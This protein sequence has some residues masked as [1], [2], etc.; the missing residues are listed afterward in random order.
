MAGGGG[1][2]NGNVDAVLHGFEHTRYQEPGAQHHGFPRLEIHLHTVRLPQMAHNADEPIDVVAGAGDVMAAAEVQPLH[3]A[4]ETPK[5]FLEGFHRLLKRVGILFT[6]CVDMQAVEQRQER[7]VEIGERCAKARTGC[8]GIVDRMAL[9][10]GTF[11]VQAQAGGF[12]R[13]PRGRG[14][15]P[16]LGRGVEHDVIRIAQQLV[17]LVLAVGRR[18]NVRFP[19]E[20]LV[21]ETRFAQAAC[22]GAGQVL[23]K[24]RIHGIHGER[25]LGKQNFA[26]C[27]L[28][29]AAQDLKVARDKR[30]IHEKIRRAGRLCELSHSSTSVGFSSI[31]Q[32]RPH[33]FKAS[34]YGSG[35][36]SSTV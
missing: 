29:H 31:C 15:P 12:P 9:L 7:F 22:R 6:E 8:A 14:K 17:P 18:E 28:L 2:E 21:A 35:S 36:N 23:P 26:A 11:R 34:M 20:F 32:G 5:L 1:V 24:Q 19:A 27:A 25:L 33:L 16:H 3:A 4:E 10:R 13:S 30:F